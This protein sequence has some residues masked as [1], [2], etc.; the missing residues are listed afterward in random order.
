MIEFLDQLS[1]TFIS[2]LIITAIILGL[3]YVVVH[4]PKL[5]FA[6]LILSVIIS[7]ASNI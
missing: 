6:L 1:S 3:F 5:V 2:L 4:Y 7:I